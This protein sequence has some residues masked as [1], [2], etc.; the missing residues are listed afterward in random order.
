MLKI[1]ERLVS[2][3]V[4]VRAQMITA[5]ADMVGRMHIIA[6]ATAMRAAMP[7]HAATTGGV[8]CG[9]AGHADADSKDHCEEFRHECPQVEAK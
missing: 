9:N 5:R 7:A 6:Q 8:G 2:A 4:A 1:E 3:A